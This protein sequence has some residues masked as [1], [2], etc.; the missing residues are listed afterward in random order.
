VVR[1]TGFVQLLLALSAAD[2]VE[3][4]S[5]PGSQ[6]TSEQL[7]VLHAPGFYSVV[8]DPFLLDKTS[9]LYHQI[10]NFKPSTDHYQ[11]VPI[12][13]LLALLRSSIHLAGFQAG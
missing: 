7:L 5:E 3:E 10:E 9:Q 2:L 11:K 1:A 12:I 6:S 13:W 8:M 4:G